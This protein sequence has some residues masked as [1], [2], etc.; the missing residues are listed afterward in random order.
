MA[1]ILLDGQEAVHL[2]VL[3]L[4]PGEAALLLDGKGRIGRCRVL[5]VGRREARLALLGWS[6]VPQPK[7]RAVMA[8]ALSKAV[9]RGFFMEKAAELGASGVWLWQG[10]HSQG[11]FPENAAAASLGQLVAGAK[12]CGNPWLPEVRAFDDIGGVI[13]QAAG[14]DFRLLPW[15]RQEGVPMLEPG[16]AGRAGVTV[17]VIGPEGGF[18]PRELAA[19]REA[20][21]TPVS[22]GA[23]ILRCETAAALCL[24]LH[25]WASQLPGGPDYRPATETPGPHDTGTEGPL[26]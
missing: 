21:F 10:D 11:R 20:A 8:L 2:R 14:A 16:M 24:G 3:R 7:S 15:E 4:E 9:R 18:S 19:L 23:R 22:L 26:P 6:F 17:Y 25:W 5:A 1:E 12:Q 13:A